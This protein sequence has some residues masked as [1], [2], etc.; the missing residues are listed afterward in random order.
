MHCY[1]ALQLHCSKHRSADVSL[2]DVLMI[3]QFSVGYE[4]GQ[5]K[6]MM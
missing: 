3:L 6:F 2:H 5:L 4:H 1:E